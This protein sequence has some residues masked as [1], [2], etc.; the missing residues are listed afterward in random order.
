[1]KSS[2]SPIGVAVDSVALFVGMVAWTFIVWAPLFLAFVLFCMVKVAVPI[3]LV[4]L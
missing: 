3:S 2:L 4:I 1:M